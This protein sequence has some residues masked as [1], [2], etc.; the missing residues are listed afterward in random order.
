MAKILKKIAALTVAV[1]MVMCFAVT[2]NAAVTFTT[3][4][5]FYATG[6]DV[7]IDVEVEGAPKNGNIIYQ[8]TQAAGGT[9][10]HF[11]QAQANTTGKATFN[12]DTA[13]TNLGANNVKIGYPGKVNAVS[14]SLIKHTVTC[15]GTTVAPNVRGEVTFT[16]PSNG[17]GVLESFEIS[18]ADGAVVSNYNFVASGSTATLTVKL[19]EISDNITV[20]Y[21]EREVAASVALGT[22][23]DSGVEATI[24]V[25]NFKASGNVNAVLLVAIYDANGAILKYAQKPVV[26]GAG[27]ALTVAEDG[28]DAKLAID[29]TGIVLNGTTPVSKAKAFLWDCGTASAPTIFNTTM[30][31]LAADAE[32]VKS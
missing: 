19:S 2:V 6:D 23:T 28:A 12:Y 11:Q 20:T 27:E 14:G 17:S 29:L 3:K 9:L 8:T 26:V 22:F 31:E 10:T 13:Y 5:T 32:S 18:P 4:T 15:G 7:R 1:I 30:V 21:A 16:V 24:S 25:S